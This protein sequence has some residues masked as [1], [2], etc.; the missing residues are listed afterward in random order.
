MNNGFEIFKNICPEAKKYIKNLLQE[1]KDNGTGILS[2]EYLGIKLIGMTYHDLIE[3]T[4]IIEKE[5]LTITEKDDTGTTYTKIHPAVQILHD[6]KLML[7]QWIEEYELIPGQ[8]RKFK[9]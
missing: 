6:D 3:A 1:L 4:K 9:R 5:G 7:N 2:H 8:L